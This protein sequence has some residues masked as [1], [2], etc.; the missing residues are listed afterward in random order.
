MSSTFPTSGVTPAAELSLLGCSA[1][2]EAAESGE[3]ATV[4]ERRD[5]PCATPEHPRALHRVAKVREQQGVSHRTLARRLGIEP[6]QLREW[7]SESHDLRAS[8]LLAI[9]A[10]L[11]VPL[12]ELLEDPQSLSRPVEE[13]A[14]LVK[15][16]KTAVAL[17]EVKASPR[18]ERLATMLCDQLIELMPELAEI[19]GWPQFGA[20][21]GESAVGRVLRNPIDTSQI[22]V[23]E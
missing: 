11:E 9:Q 16:M 7:E 5:A 19:S 23:P 10:A 21:R 17:R 14:K 22:I 15:V 1:K 2:A 12:I 3:S 6:R 18:V 4:R 13:R 20:R 8:Q